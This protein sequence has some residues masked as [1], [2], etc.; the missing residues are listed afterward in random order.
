MT[1]LL[2][3]WLWIGAIAIVT[4]I[5]AATSPYS[6]PGSTSHHLAVI[7]AIIAWPLTL[8][9]IVLVCLIAACYCVPRVLR[10]LLEDQ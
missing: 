2:W 1:E 6:A 8:V 3:L 5:W 9:I 10:W 4:Y 7:G